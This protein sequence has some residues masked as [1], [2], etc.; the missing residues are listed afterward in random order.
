MPINF[1]SFFFLFLRKIE[2]HWQVGKQ[3]CKVARI[4]DQSSISSG[5]ACAELVGLLD[6]FPHPPDQIFDI[7]RTSLSNVWP[8]KIARNAQDCLSFG[9]F[10]LYGRYVSQWC[11]FRT[12]HNQVASLLQLNRRNRLQR[13]CACT[14]SQ[15]FW[16]WGKILMCF[17]RLH[18]W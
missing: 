4:D 9:C 10:E 16:S 3:L 7:T 5:S 8:D 15:V 1:F 14:V 2:T 11:Q 17:F 6:N 12:A 18:L 13:P